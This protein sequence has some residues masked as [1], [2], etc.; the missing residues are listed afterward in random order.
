MT[1]NRIVDDIN[2]NKIT[3]N[4]TKK[5]LINI[6]YDNK[7]MY[8]QTPLLY[9]YNKIEN[10]ENNDYVTHQLTCS[11]NEEN[12]NN[13]T[14]SFFENLDDKII[15]DIKENKENWNLPE[16]VTFKYTVMNVNNDLY[17]NGAIK[18]K[19]LKTNDSVTKVYSEN[20]EL[21]SCDD[22]ENYTSTIDCPFFVRN[23]LEIVGIWIKNNGV[24]VYI[25]LHQQQ[26]LKIDKINLDDYSFCDPDNKNDD[27]NEDETLYLDTE[28]FK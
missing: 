20:E 26:I 22:Y 25:K 3:Y 24:G 12:D 15:Q 7:K 6:K 8:I 14:V 23:I 19:Y 17:K 13:Y 18:F 16:D 9:C 1:I 4:K 27:E 21:L 5:N 2:L 28:I 11:L 10:V